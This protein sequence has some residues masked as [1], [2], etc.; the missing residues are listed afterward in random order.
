MQAIVYKDSE[1]RLRAPSLFHWDTKWINR[2]PKDAAGDQKKKK[3]KM[4]PSSKL[5]VFTMSI[6]LTLMAQ[7]VENLPAM[8][9]TWVQSLGW[10]DPL[11][12]QM[13]THSSYSCWRIPWTEEPGGLQS[14]GWQGA[15]RDWAS[16]SP[17]LLQLQLRMFS[18]ILHCFTFWHLLKFL[19]VGLFNLKSH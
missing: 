3:K 16:N 14:T 11:E 12:K 15:G 4:E 5:K 17:S 18:A 19:S 1:Q 2:I 8:Q 10:E 9:E 7:T 6:V 13:A